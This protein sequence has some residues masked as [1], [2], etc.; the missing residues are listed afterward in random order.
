VI[1]LGEALR[2]AGFLRIARGPLRVAVIDSGIYAGHPHVPQIAGGVCL[3]PGASP[4]DLIDRNGHGTA[5]AAAIVEK[6]PGI[7]LFAVKVF[8]RTLA[9]TA[10]ALARGM[11][12]SAEHGADV[13]NLSLGTTNPAH[14]ALLQRAVDAARGCGAIIVAATDQG[15][16]P[17]LPGSLTGVVAVSLDWDCPRDTCLVEAV[18]R[19]VVRVRASGYPR[20]IPGVP[21]AKNLSGISFAVANVTG[22][23]ARQLTSNWLP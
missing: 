10:A 8:D 4:D 20:P 3:I 15:G 23:I 18:D 5:V 19:D 17:S 13:I 22:L 12:W 9:T 14:A 7:D 11:E 6:A 1:P 16:L 2:D 21:P